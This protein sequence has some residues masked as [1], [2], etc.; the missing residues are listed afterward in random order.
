MER[1]A[2]FAAGLFYFEGL[3]KFLRHCL[4]I[5][6]K[7]LHPEFCTV[8][9]SGI[10]RRSNRTQATKPV[11]EYAAIPA[12]RRSCEFASQGHQP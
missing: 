9:R 8:D 1:P 4:K 3:G 12:M 7:M 10:F 6:L 2:A 5:G 11:D